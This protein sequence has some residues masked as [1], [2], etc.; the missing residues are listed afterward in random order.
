MKQNC[1]CS[2]QHLIVCGILASAEQDLEEPEDEEDEEISGPWQYNAVEI[3]FDK[4]PE[5]I[6]K[7]SPS[8]SSGH[9]I[10]LRLH[11]GHL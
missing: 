8:H 9:N 7:Y 4:P 11:E 5:E 1:L 6:R 10:Y 2:N 3:V